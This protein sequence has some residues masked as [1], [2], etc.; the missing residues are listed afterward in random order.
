MWNP[1]TGIP[2]RCYEDV[3]TQGYITKYLQSLFTDF[4][5]HEK[6]FPS[7]EKKRTSLHS[8]SIF[9]QF[10]LLDLSKYLLFCEFRRW[11]ST[12]TRNKPSN[13]GN[14]KTINIVLVKQRRCPCQWTWSVRLKIK[15]YII[16]ENT[17]YFYL[18]KITILIYILFI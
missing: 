6:N 18:E 16:F 8:I 7:E 13:L 14:Y 9:S 17:K 10:L 4:P 1:V 12:T 5:S 2:N 15:K 11:N 3:P